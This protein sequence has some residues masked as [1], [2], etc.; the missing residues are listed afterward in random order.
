MHTAHKEEYELDQELTLW[1]DRYE[2][3]F[4]PEPIPKGF[5][6]GYIGTGNPY[7]RHLSAGQ[8]KKSD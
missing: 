5:D 2:Q 7:E 8:S 6:P 1:F 4:F 3:V